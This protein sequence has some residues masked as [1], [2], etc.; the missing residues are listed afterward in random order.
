MNERITLDYG[1]GGR[2]T[3]ELIESILL[4]AFDNPALSLLG[5]GAVLEGRKAFGMRNCERPV[6]GRR[7][8]Q[9]FKPVLHPG[10]RI[11]LF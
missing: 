2:K 3:A 11:S 1:S 7:N 6:H 10:G 5:D 4:P 9:I 8:T